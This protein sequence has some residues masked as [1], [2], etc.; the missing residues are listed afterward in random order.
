MELLLDS[1][2]GPASE[3]AKDERSEQRK[4]KMMTKISMKAVMLNQ[5]EP[6]DP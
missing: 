1:I 2:Q 6:W 3:R 5:R 4:R